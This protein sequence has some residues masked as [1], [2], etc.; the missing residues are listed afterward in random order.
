MS[1]EIREI[2]SVV[3]D[4]L[5]EIAKKRSDILVLD[6]DVSKSTCTRKF[7]EVFPDRFFNVGVAEM[8][9]AGIAAGLAASGK[10]P[11]IST[12]ATFMALRALEPIR[13]M[14]SYPKLNVK[15]LGGYSGLTAHQHGPTH[16]CLRD[17]ATMRV[18]P[19]LTV[20]SPS[21]WVQAGKCAEAMV[22]TDGPCYVRLGYT[23]KGNIHPEGMAFSIGK[24]Y[25]IKDGSDL[26]ILSTGVI[27]HRVLEAAE[28]LEQDG[29]S[30][31]VIDCPT[32]KPLDETAILTA[33]KETGRI[34]T[35]EEHS[36]IGGFGGAVAELLIQNHPVPMKILGVDDIFTE[37]APYEELLDEYGLGKADIV[38]AAK[39][40]IEY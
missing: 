30:V 32:I 21:D 20:L 29:V 19:N 28:Q 17:I 3:M 5:I 39:S 12:F 13:S 2:R 14:I 38:N 37:S 15:M 16:H 1:C 35:M 7:G 31:R 11:V 9:M 10:T 26:T 27:L 8:N 22:S 34:V 33:A 6:A 40:L 24:S 4:T 18:L 25:T 36:T 23:K